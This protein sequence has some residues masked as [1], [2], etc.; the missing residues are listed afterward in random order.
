MGGT[1]VIGIS[2]CAVTRDPEASLATYALGSCIAV[3][4]HDPVA[5]VAGMLHFLLPDSNLDV[6]RAEAKPFM[7]ADKGI[8]MLVKQLIEAGADKKRLTVWVAGGAQVLDDKGVFDIGKRNHVSM[9]KAM[10]KAGLLVHAEATGGTISRS[11]RLENGTG[12]FWVREGA[13]PAKEL[14]AGIGRMERSLGSV[15]SNSV[16]R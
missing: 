9:R 4:I 14:P 5:K 3:A 1:I 16:G 6:S 10:W 12:K 11:V 8:P 15:P 7:F 2:E 13:Q